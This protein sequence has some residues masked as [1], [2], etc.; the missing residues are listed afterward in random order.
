MVEMP[1]SLLRSRSRAWAP[2]AAAVLAASATS[3]RADVEIRGDPSGVHME[4]SQATRWEALAALGSAF[5]LRYRTS[6][7]LE[8]TLTGTYAGSLAQVLSRVLDG[9]DYVVKTEEGSTE[10]IVI[11]RHGNRAVAIA[12]PPVQAP[13]H[14][15]TE[16]R[17]EPPRPATQRR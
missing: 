7:P 2:L 9:Y 1:G 8:G 15:A 5:G 4:A 17:R 6:A 10:V 13:R 12:P 11:G 14:T 3:A 16:W